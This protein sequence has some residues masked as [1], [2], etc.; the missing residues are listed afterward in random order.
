[1]KCHTRSRY[2]LRNGSIRPSRENKDSAAI[3][4]RLIRRIKYRRYNAKTNE[5]IASIRTTIAH[6]PVR[7][8][9]SLKYVAIS[10]ITME[11]AAPNHHVTI[12]FARSKC[13][14]N[15]FSMRSEGSVVCDNTRSIKSRT[16]KS[17]MGSIRA[18]S[19]RSRITTA[20][21]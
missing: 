2:I 16:V 12:V 19:H 15:I 11:E 20:S 5:Q 13:H 1:M 14:S 17:L 6:Q 21:P 8:D 7:R 3:N 9:F 18:D 4:S 10:A